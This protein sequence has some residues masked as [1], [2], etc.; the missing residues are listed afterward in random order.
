MIADS[1]RRHNTARGMRIVD[2][3]HPPQGRVCPIGAIIGLV[4]DRCWTAEARRGEY[5]IV[6]TTAHRWNQRARIQRAPYPYKE[7]P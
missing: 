7:I 2:S 1:S 5:A 3:L 6:V 4:V